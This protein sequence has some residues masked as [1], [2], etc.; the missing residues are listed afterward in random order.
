LARRETK[1]ID[2]EIFAL[3]REYNT[4]VSD[5]K[6]LDAQARQEYEFNVQM[7]NKKMQLAEQMYNIQR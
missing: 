1:A 5:Y 6:Y 2:D 3:E 7:A 4:A